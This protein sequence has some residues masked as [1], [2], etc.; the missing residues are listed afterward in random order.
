MTS[1]TEQ[2]L[3]AQ[4][5]ALRRQMAQQRLR[6]SLLAAPETAIN[7][8]AHKPLPRSITMRLITQHPTGAVKVVSQIAL[9]LF[10]TR[11]VRSL[12]SLM[13]LS[14]LVRSIALDP[15]KR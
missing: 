2:N 15:R 14:K 5:L 12:N 4:R 3:A 11:T 8:E 9:L 13:I 7:K 1:T 6:I 10:G